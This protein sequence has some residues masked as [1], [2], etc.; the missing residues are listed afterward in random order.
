MLLE[1][2]GFSFEVRPAEVDESTRPAES[3]ADYVE[4]LAALKAAAATAVAPGEITLGADTTVALDGN[5][6]GKPGSVDEARRMLRALSG[7]SHRVLTAIA[8]AGA[9][10]ASRRVE[11]TV[12]FRELSPAE[13]D[14][15]V[16]TG[17]PMDKAGAYGAQ[18]I[19]GFLIE[20][21][22]GSHS[23]VVGLPLAE[24]LALLAE[25]GLEMPWSTQ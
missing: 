13:I 6:L 1:Q 8:L 16:R 2:L 3:P 17:E 24:T 21:I 15:Y 23:N 11:T 10:R 19:G 25:A 12:D 14:W 9:H 7:R 5:I 20:A 22:H 4:R 18:G